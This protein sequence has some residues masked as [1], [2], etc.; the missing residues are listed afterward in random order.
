MKQGYGTYE[1]DYPISW[2][3]LGHTR[4]QSPV[5]AYAKG[6]WQAMLEN[7]KNHGRTSKNQDAA[8]T[9]TR[10]LKTRALNQNNGKQN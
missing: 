7:G 6:V 5:H 2:K 4:I 9:K 3:I 10:T 1:P 8:L